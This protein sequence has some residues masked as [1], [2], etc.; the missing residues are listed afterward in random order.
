MKNSVLIG[1]VALIVIGTSFQSTQEKTSSNG[2]IGDVK[3]S[4]LP[5]TRFKE[6]NPGWVLM[7]GRDVIGS[8]YHRETGFKSIPNGTNN[9]V[10]GMSDNRKVGEFQNSSTAKPKNKSFL[11]K[12][13]SDGKHKH[14][15]RYRKRY[16]YNATGAPTNK[17]GG[18]FAMNW[19]G[20]NL[21]KADKKPDQ[22]SFQDGGHNHTINSENWDGETRPDNISLYIYIKIN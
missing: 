2:T 17:W 21:T 14:K 19:N 16:D 8:E 15:L 22:F 10:R 1:L 4:V 20:K 6:L 3:Y 9:F 13:T 5:E 7:D 18:I 11:I 12:I